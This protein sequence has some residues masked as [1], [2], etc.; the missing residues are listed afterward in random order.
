M[1][2]V[3][4][5]NNSST[6]TLAFMTYNSDACIICFR[7]TS[8]GKNWITNLK[9]IPYDNAFPPRYKRMGITVHRGFNEALLAVWDELMGF[10]EEAYLKNPQM[11]L[12]IFGHSLGGALALLA[13]AHLTFTD[14]PRQV[15]AL[16]T[17][18]QPWYVPLGPLP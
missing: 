17:I 15:R 13:L 5:L 3:V 9:F 7:G 4:V 10:V 12:Y 1:E 14:T 6:D 11:E 2:D 16:Y 8:T 18:G